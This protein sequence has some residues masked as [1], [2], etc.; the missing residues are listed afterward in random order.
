MI[1]ERH[2][3]WNTVNVHV[4][5]FRLLYR[6][7]LKRGEDQFHLPPRGRVGQRP[8]ILDRASVA[9]VLAAAA[10]LRA[11][12]LL[13]MV[14]GSGLRVSE[15]CR[16]RACHIESSPERMLVRVEQS[17]VRKDRYTLLSQCALELLREYWRR[18]R[19]REWLF[20]GIGGLAPISVPTVQR[21]YREAC[22]A[23]GVDRDRARGIHTL[24]HCFASHLMED[25]VALP[26][27][28]QLLG[29]TSLKTTSVYCHVSR[30][31]LGSVRSPAD[32]P[33]NGRPL[34]PHGARA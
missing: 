7:V 22:L 17:K 29:H 30:A 33:G 12:A 32:M 13:A 28:Q 34:H 20:P 4:C 2:L 8:T 21:M 31:L 18:H 11:R 26:V 19:P 14:Y 6:D 5:A 27:I 9:A 15:V 3:A 24:R 10:D 16:L 25:G 1:G 23:A